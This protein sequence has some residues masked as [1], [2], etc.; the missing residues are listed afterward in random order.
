MKKIAIYFSDPEPMGYPFHKKEYYE[1]YQQIISQIE[2]CGPEVYIVRA[3]SYLGA[4]EFKAGWR[5]ESGQLKKTNTEFQADLIFNRD[6]KNT[7]PNIYDCP[8][9]N[10]PEFD[11]ICVDKFKTFEL[12][13]DISPKTAYIHTYEACHLEL[14]IWK[15]QPNDLVV[16]KKNFET[17]GR[18][19]FI[20]QTK[21]IKKDLYTDWSDII[22]QEFID[23]SIGIPKIAS[24]LHDIRITVIGGTPINSFVRVPKKGSYLAN[25]AQGGAGTSI[26]L[27]QVPKEVI[28]LVSKVDN[29][30]EKFFPILYAADFMNSP[31]GYKLVELNSRPGVQH[32]NWSKTY[33]IF[34]DSIIKLLVDAVH[35]RSELVNTVEVN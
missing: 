11:E 15:L 31:K 9:I 34:N 20:I 29:T 22:I 25:I 33:N 26:D 14:Q 24:G 4:G 21:D 32:P 13:P 2:K 16:L 10:K 30:I 19:I 23:S 3:D 1:T 35:G 28:D 6:D 27:K 17:E 7:I 5:F 8:I 18:G 12:F